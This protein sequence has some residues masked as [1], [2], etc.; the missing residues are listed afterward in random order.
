MISVFGSSGATAAH[1]SYQACSVLS[2]A[3]SGTCV[4]APPAAARRHRRATL[5]M[6]AKT[7][8]TAGF[9]GAWQTSIRTSFPAGVPESETPVHVAPPFVERKSPSSHA[10]NSS[11][12]PVGSMEI[13]HVIL[14]RRSVQVLP[15]LAL[16]ESPFHVP[17]HRCFGVAGSTATAKKPVPTESA[18]EG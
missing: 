2:P 11:P 15:P 5:P 1:Q 3:G 12:P 7:Y 17:A 18:A 10:A 4:K 16:S 9:A 13:S 6:V 8:A 14:L